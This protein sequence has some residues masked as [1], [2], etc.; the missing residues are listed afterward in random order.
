MFYNNNYELIASYPFV[1]TDSCIELEE[2][3]FNDK[4]K[5]MTFNTW[6]SAQNG[7][8]GLYRVSEIIANL[9][10]DVI[11]FQ[12]TDSSSIIEIKSLL[13]NFEGYSQ[14]YSTPSESNISIISRF[15]IIETYDY[16]LYGI[17]ADLLISN[18][19]LIHIS[20]PTRP[21]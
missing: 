3:V 15:P 21:Y 10:I 16:N 7:F 9:N 12:E 14:L 2:I 18:L 17:G 5:V 19:S 1:V 11:G 8:G 4:F 6:Y 20:E 13:S